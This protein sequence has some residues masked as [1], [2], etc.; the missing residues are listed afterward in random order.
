MSEPNL[1]KRLKLALEVALAND[2]V[3]DKLRE[4]T[5]RQKELTEMFAFLLDKTS[6]KL[7]EKQIHEMIVEYEREQRRR[8]NTNIGV[9]RKVLNYE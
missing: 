6:L 4:L 5:E 3:A 2:R 7:T 8:K 1:D 9:L